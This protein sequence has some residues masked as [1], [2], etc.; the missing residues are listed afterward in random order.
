MGSYSSVL[1]LGEKEASSNLVL[2][3]FLFSVVKCHNERSKSKMYLID[4]E[5]NVYK[6]D[7][8]GRNPATDFAIVVCNILHPYFHLVVHSILRDGYWLCFSLTKCLFTSSAQPV[9]IV[10]VELV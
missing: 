5:F 1:N 6:N 3:P 4:A 7:A 9:R 10:V 2:S 8:R